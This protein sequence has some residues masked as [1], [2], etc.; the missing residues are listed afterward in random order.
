MS[1]VSVNYYCVRNHFQ[2][3]ALNKNHLLPSWFSGLTELI[4]EILFYTMLAVVI[5]GPDW[6]G[7]S[8]VAVSY[9]WC[10]GGEHGKVGTAGTLG[11]LGA[12]C[13]RM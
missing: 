10:L 9:D 1:P 13:L 2:T 4:W 11:Q 12:P 6:T 3:V 8:K 7:T 5:C